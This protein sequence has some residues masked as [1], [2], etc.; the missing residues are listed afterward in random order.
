MEALTLF[1]KLHPGHRTKEIDTAIGKA[2]NFLEK[3]QRADGSWFVFLATCCFG[4]DKRGQ[5]I[6]S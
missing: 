4:T 6:Y 1:K 5:G 2:A 3:M